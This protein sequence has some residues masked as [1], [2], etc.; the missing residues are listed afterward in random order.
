M[1]V[2]M[3]TFQGK[4]IIVPSERVVSVAGGFEF[5]TS[6]IFRKIEFADKSG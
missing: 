2:R 3:Q 1:Y 5:F 4:P 6:E